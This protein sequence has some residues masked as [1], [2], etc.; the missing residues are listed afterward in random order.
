MSAAG[1]ALGHA[2]LVAVTGVTGYVGGRLVPELLDAGYRV[3]ALARNPARLRDRPWSADVEA[4]E[5]DA[6]DLDQLRAALAGVSVLDAPPLD[7]GF[8]TSGKQQLVLAV[9][10]AEA[11]RFFAL[12]GGSDQATVTVVRRG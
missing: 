3:R 8:A 10:E 4:V 1:G 9:P 11:Q 12:L 6:D 5:A 7:D 2:E